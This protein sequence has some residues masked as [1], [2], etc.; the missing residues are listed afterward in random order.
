M[1]LILLAA[2]SA[3]HPGDLDARAALA[4]ASVPAAKKSAPR[5][6]PPA[7]AVKPCPCGPLCE[8]PHCEGGG[9]ACHCNDPAPRRG[10]GTIAMGTTDRAMFR[11]PPVRLPAHHNAPAFRAAPVRYA[12]PRPAAPAPARVYSRPAVAPGGC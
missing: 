4:L 6:R 10:A 5:E 7:K 2:L 8:C 1:H 11:P 12:P 9:E 3:G